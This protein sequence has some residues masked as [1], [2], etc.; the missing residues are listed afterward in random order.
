MS[1]ISPWQK[2]AGAVAPKITRESFTL[3]HVGGV[4][5]AMGAQGQGVCGRRCY[6][7]QGPSRSLKPSADLSF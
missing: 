5:Q 4:E 7:P 1:G 3:A 2:R 6:I